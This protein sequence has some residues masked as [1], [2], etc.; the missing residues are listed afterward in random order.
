MVP[1]PQAAHTLEA[2][3]AVPQVSYKKYFKILTAKFIVKISVGAKFN[4][5]NHHHIIYSRL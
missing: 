3:A 5:K 2:G 4:S 1:P